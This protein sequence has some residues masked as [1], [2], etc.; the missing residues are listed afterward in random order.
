MEKK[1]RSTFP[2]KTIIS[3]AC[4]T[5]ATTPL[6]QHPTPS[7]PHAQQQ[8][9]N[10]VG[11]A[12]QQHPTHTIADTTLSPAHHCSNIV[13]SPLYAVTPYARYCSN[14]LRHQCSNATTQH[15]LHSQQNHRIPAV[16]VSYWNYNILYRVVTANVSVAN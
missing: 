15:H 16:F 12:P 6:Q 13:R 2:L 10:T 1:A 3:L 8:C 9:T 4:P 11:P 5:T 7:P 14:T